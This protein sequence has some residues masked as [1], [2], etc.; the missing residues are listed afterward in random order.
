MKHFAARI[1]LIYVPFLVIAISFI[2]IYS[3]LH[4][5]LIIKLDLPLDEDLVHFWLIFGLPFIPVFIWLRPRIR[6]LVLNEKRNLPFLYQF[7]AVIVVVIPC[8]IAQGYLETATGKLTPLQNIDQIDA[9]PLT[10]YYT[11]KSHFVDKQHIGVYRRLVTSGRSNEYLEYDVDIACPILLVPIVHQKM[12]SND[13]P[14]ILPDPKAWLCLEFKDNMSNRL[15]DDAKQTE[16]RAFDATVNK[17]FNEKQLD[18]FTYL[19]RIGTNARRKAYV[20]A[21]HSQYNDISLL[22][23]K[24]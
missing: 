7:A 24:P 15:S 17:E 18:V 8:I 13:L 11:L 14:Y 9:Q 10:K 20:K 2:V 23:W 19:D 5:L 12:D 3:F 4:W 16:F 21:I 1:R 6:L 22:Y